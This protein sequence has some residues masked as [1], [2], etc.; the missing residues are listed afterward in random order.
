VKDFESKID[1]MDDHDQYNMLRDI[2]FM[3]RDYKRA[4][5]QNEDG[6]HYL[7]ILSSIVSED[8]CNYINNYIETHKDTLVGT[9]KY[10]IYKPYESGKNGWKLSCSFSPKLNMKEVPKL[11]R[12]FRKFT[13][14]KILKVYKGTDPFRNLIATKTDYD[15]LMEA[16][17]DPAYIEPYV[18]DIIAAL[19]EVCYRD[20]MQNNIILHHTTQ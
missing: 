7:D 19:N 15:N 1:I 8:A 6:E 11:V 20:L 2:E 12:D 3:C 9:D 13:V 5:S 4:I 18:R 10:E 14:I 17:K 16:R